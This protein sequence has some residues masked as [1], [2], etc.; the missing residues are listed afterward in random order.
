MK[1]KKLAQSIELPDGV[2]VAKKLESS[3]NNIPKIC[4]GNLLSNPLEIGKQLFL[5]GD[6]GLTTTA[7]KEI[8]ILKDNGIQIK[9]KNSTYVLY[10]L[11]EFKDKITVSDLY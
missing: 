5:V 4:Q 6:L 7:I 9:T 3:H 10:P 11:E 1:N 8:E 2:Y